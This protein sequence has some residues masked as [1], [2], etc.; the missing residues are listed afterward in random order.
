MRR[1]RLWPALAGLCLLAATVLFIVRHFGGG[2]EVIDVHACTGGPTTAGIDV[3]YHQDTID[4]RRVRRADV[5][6]AFIRVSDG[7]TVEDPRFGPNWDGARKAGILR[8]AYQFFRPEE[9]AN[10]QADLLIAAIA[11]DPGELPPVLDVE[12]TG[13]RSPAKLEAANTLWLADGRLHADNTDAHGFAANL[14]DRA[15]GTAP[16]ALIE[17]AQRR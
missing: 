7:L 13:G 4:W 6:F 11:R 3:S 14:D 12:V 5:R 16:A 15:P 17:A 9:S 8:G 10:A 1:N 2:G